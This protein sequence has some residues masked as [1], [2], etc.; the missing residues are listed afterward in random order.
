M[1]LIPEW[2]A[3]PQ[4]QAVA[5]EPL[6]GILVVTAALEKIV[7]TFGR[8]NVRVNN[9]GTAIPKRFEETTVEELDRVIDRQYECLRSR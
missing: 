6:D 4:G 3:H 2:K 8:L 1:R 9:A 7:P 5:S